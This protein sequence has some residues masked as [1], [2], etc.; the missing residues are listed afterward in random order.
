ME[1]V[2]RI[3][4]SEFKVLSSNTYRFLLRSQKTRLTSYLNQINYDTGYWGTGFF[5]Y[6]AGTTEYLIVEGTGTPERTGDN[7]M[8]MLFR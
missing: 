6:W 3:P 1:A 8:E 4:T 2:D 7:A 5:G